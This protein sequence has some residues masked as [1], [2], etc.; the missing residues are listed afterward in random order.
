MLVSGLSVAASLVNS[1]VNIDREALA[2]CLSRLGAS[3]QN[4]ITTCHLFLFSEKYFLFFV[5]FLWHL[6]IF[7]FYMTRYRTLDSFTRH[8]WR[9]F[10]ASTLLCFLFW[11]WWEHFIFLVT[12]FSSLIFEFQHDVWSFTQIWKLKMCLSEVNIVESDKSSEGLDSN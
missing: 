9:C 10:K 7:F 4:R 8:W 3:P 6:A 5:L 1:L 12:F 2:K 11:L